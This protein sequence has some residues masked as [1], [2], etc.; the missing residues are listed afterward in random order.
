MFGQLTDERDLQSLDPRDAWQQAQKG[1]L[2]LVDV[3]PKARYEEAHPPGAQSAQLYRK[4]LPAAVHMR[5]AGHARPR[6][7]ISRRVRLQTDFSQFSFQRYFK[8]A[9]LMANGIEVCPPPGK[10]H[11]TQLAGRSKL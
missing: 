9:A 5:S 2:V 8:A 11:L 10:E 3:R 4:V 7:A 1:K 6:G